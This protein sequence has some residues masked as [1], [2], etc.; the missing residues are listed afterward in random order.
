MK[1]VIYLVMLM[2][3]SLTVYS[4]DFAGKD[5]ELYLNKTVKPKEISKILQ[6]HHY[7]NF[8]LNYEKGELLNE[9]KRNRPFPTGNRYS[10][11]SDYTKLVGVE[12]K[13]VDVMK[14]KEKYSFRQNYML[15]LHNETI[16]DLYYKYDTRYSHD[17]ELEVVGGLD[18][19]EGYFCKFLKVKKS[20]FEEDERIYSPDEY[21]FSFV[22]VKNKDN[23]VI[24]LSVERGGKT[25]FTNK[26]GFYLLLD[27]GT[28]IAKPNEEID[29][30]VSTS[31][32][33]NY[34]YSVFVKLTDEDIKLLTKHKITDYKLYI[35]EG[36][37]R[38]EGSIKLMEYLKC[39][40]K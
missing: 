12:F 1:K 28:K 15:K 40:T 3:F 38:K 8:F 32:Y 6:E 35:L 27:D 21:G 24:Y 25:L 26:T 37:L 11:K 20:K 39:M 31:K 5:V 29:V 36:E 2:M 33:S 4:Q 30:K 23:S 22:K 13:V 18:Y 7:E 10:P 34:D 17:L 14:L 16:G 19:P 9:K